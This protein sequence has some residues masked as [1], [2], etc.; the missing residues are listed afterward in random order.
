MDAALLH[1]LHPEAYHR[2]HHHRKL[3]PDNRP[4]IPITINANE[5]QKS[6]IE[7]TSKSL[8]KLQLQISKARDSSNSSE[9]ASLAQRNDDGSVR[10]LCR[11]GKTASL[12]TVRPELLLLPQNT[13]EPTADLEKSTIDN[14]EEMVMKSVEKS[15]FF[16]LSGIQVAV[17]LSGPGSGSGNAVVG[18]GTSKDTGG[19]PTS[20]LGSSSTDAGLSP[21]TVAQQLNYFAEQ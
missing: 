16:I 7:I 19:N 1:V 9:D 13:T 6:K 15:P 20:H 14:S 17:Q 4:L 2:H 11:I 18:F 8:R 5:Q 21:M 3:R 10:A 12:C